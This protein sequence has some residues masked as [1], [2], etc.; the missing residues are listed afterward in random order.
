M[1]TDAAEVELEID[2]IDATEVETEVD[3]VEE[4]TDE[5]TGDEESPD[6][7]SSASEKEDGEKA[8]QDQ[9]DKRIGEI[10]KLR[11]EEERQ[12]IAAQDETKALREQLEAL[13]PKQPPGMTLADFEYDEGKFSEYLGNQANERAQAAVH[14]RM[15]VEKRQQQQAD[16]SVRESD[17]SSDFDDYHTVTRNNDLK[18]TQDMVN[19]A[20]GS[21]HGPAIL[22]HLGKNPD[23]SERLSHMAPMDMARELGRIEATQLAK[24]PSVTKAPAAPTKL[25]GTSQATTIRSD[26]AASDSL[27]TEEWRKREHKRMANRNK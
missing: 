5:A 15:D 2:A 27:S 25:S 13:K 3:E 20:Q 1:S 16:F 24:P 21:E 11:R 23:V 10:T 9:I 7:E 8:K 22:Y 19:V 18:L 26:S 14:Q 6:E 4:V 17:Y 12:R